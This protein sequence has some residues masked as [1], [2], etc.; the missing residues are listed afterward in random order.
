MLRSVWRPLH[1]PSHAALLIDIENGDFYPAASGRVQPGCARMAA[2]RWAGSLYL[3]LMPD[4]WP[5]RRAIWRIPRIGA[6]PHPQM[7]N[8]S[9]PLTSM[10]PAKQPQRRAIWENSQIHLLPPDLLGAQPLHGEREG[11]RH[12]PA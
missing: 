4:R 12:I 10:M 2:P 7:R 3:A 9:P 11:Y 8:S 5:E 6:V 1:S